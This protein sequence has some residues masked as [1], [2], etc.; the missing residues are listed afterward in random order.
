MTVGDRLR[1]I[2][3][4]KTLQEF[5]EKLEVG[6][7]NISNVENGRSKLSTDLAM[8]IAKVYEVSLDW[9]LMGEGTMK[10]EENISLSMEPSSD[11][12]TI[13]KDE[14]IALQRA[15]LEKKDVALEKKDV[16]LEEKEQQLTRLKNDR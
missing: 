2:R 13:T 10:R 5:A 1:Q 6:G 9:L 8:R 4:M 7:S 11:Y 3:G 12:V 16:A 15:A 14:L